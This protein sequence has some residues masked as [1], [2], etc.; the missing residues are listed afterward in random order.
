MRAP[1]APLIRITNC[2]IGCAAIKKSSPLCL[3][4]SDGPPCAGRF[5]L[6]AFNIAL[7]ACKMFTLQYLSGL[8][9]Q[10]MR[11]RLRTK[12][13]IVGQFWSVKC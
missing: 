1:Y 7:S 8:I 11:T 5:L 12:L 2:G 10:K 9:A 6:S 13:T 3:A 4:C